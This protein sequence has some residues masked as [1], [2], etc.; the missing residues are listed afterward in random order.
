MTWK[1]SID[2]DTSLQAL[3]VEAMGR[4]LCVAIAGLLSRAF[5]RSLEIIGEAAKKVPGDLIGAPG[6][7]TL[8]LGAV[9]HSRC[10]LQRISVDGF[11]HVE[12][13]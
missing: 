7:L 12:D 1:P 11:A 10:H 8:A 5:V 9:D 3:G 2:E 13:S 4:T 6:E